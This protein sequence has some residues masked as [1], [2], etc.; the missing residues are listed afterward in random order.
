MPQYPPFTKPAF[1]IQQTLSYLTL[2]T[3]VS[4]ASK[5]RRCQMAGKCSAFWCLQPAL[6]PIYVSH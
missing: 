2:S 5:T 6:N 1:T 4:V 3:T